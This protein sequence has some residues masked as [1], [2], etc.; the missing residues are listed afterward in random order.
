MGDVKVVDTIINEITE[1]NMTLKRKM[2]VLKLL[3]KAFRKYHG[4]IYLT[5]NELDN[6]DILI[7]SM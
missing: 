1:S 2:I 4:K 7:R 5:D 3:D 6:N